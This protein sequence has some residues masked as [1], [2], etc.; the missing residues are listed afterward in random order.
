[1]IIFRSH[2]KCVSHLASNNRKLKQRL[3]RKG[4]LFLISACVRLMI[5]GG[6]NLPNEKQGYPKLSLFTNNYGNLATECRHKTSLSTLICLFTLN[7]Y[8]VLK[9]QGGQNATKLPHPQ[10]PG[11]ATAPLAPPVTQALSSQFIFFKTVSLPRNLQSKSL[12]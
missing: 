5:Q 10:I 4:S 1:M 2:F 12:F 7:F 8:F 9:F 3:K 11:G 6:P